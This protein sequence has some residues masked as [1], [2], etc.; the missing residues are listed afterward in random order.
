VRR[1]KDALQVRRVSLHQ[2]QLR[3]QAFEWDSP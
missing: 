1:L 2:R 3:G